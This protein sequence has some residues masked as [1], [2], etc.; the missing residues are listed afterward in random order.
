MVH[1]L[2]P[3]TVHI[4]TTIFDPPAKLINYMELTAAIGMAYK[5]AG[6]DIPKAETGESVKEFRNRTIHMVQNNLN[7][8]EKLI[9]VI[10]NYVLKVGEVIDDDSQITMKLGYEYK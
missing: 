4:K 3:D 10:K 6:L 7:V 2:V 8:N 5:Q 9:Q 1:S